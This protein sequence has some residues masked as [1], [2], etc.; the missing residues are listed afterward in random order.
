MGMIYSTL[1]QKHFSAR[2]LAEALVLHIKIRIKAGSYYKPAL[3]R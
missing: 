3:L 1:V 2:V